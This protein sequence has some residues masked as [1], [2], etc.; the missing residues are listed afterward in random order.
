MEALAKLMCHQSEE[1]DTTSDAGNGNEKMPC[2]CC[3]NEG[4]PHTYVTRITRIVGV[5]MRTVPSTWVISR[6][7]WK[8]KMAPPTTS[9]NPDNDTR[10]ISQTSSITHRQSTAIA[11]IYPPAQISE[12]GTATI[13]GLLRPPDHI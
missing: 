3:T 5:V 11:V 9:G 2:I 10:Y 1:R 6:R 12:V 13:T 7:E 4:C 8:S